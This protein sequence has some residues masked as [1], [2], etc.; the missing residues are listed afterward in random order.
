VRQLHHE[1]AIP[2]EALHDLGC[3]LLAGAVRVECEHDAIE[4]REAV[5][6]RGD[7]LACL[8]P[9]P[10]PNGTDSAGWPSA[11][12]ATASNSP[13]TIT[14]VRAFAGIACQPNSTGSQ[15][16]STRKPFGRRRYFVATSSPSIS[17]GNRISSPLLQ[18]L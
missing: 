10:P 6:L 17:D 4:R 9:P 8:S 2:P 15:F 12:I 13:S 11:C 18:S 5:E 1:A 14:T 16:A 7:P 3:G